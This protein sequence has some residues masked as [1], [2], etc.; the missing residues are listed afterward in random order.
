MMGAGFGGCTI[1][2]VAA[3]RTEEFE[4]AMRRALPEVQILQVSIGG[5]TARV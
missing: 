3:S 5:G 4:A 2:L 1:N